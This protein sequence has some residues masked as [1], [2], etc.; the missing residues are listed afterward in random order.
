MNKKKFKRKRSIE[1]ILHKTIADG[2][3]RDPHV[4]K[5]EFEYSKDPPF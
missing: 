1:L 2:G 3:T 5:F 4:I